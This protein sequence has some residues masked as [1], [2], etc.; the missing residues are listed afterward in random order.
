MHFILAKEL[1]QARDIFLAPPLE[2]VPAPRE[3]LGE[4]LASSWGG[5][6]ET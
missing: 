2:L 3:I 6:S 4:I 5:V 1:S